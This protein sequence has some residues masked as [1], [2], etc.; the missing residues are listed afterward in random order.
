MKTTTKQPKTIFGWGGG[1]LSFISAMCAVFALT[2]AYAAQTFRWVDGSA[3]WSLPASYQG[4]ETAPGLGDTVEIPNNVT[5][6]VTNAT[7][8][9]V[10]TNLAWIKLLGTKSRVVFDVPENEHYGV[11]CTIRGTSTANADCGV[12]E[13]VKR[14]GGELEFAMSDHTYDGTSLL[15]TKVTVEEGT[16]V[17]PQNYAN[18]QSPINYRRNCNCGIVSVSNG[19]TVVTAGIRDASSS[20]QYGVTVFYELWGEGVV[21]NRCGSPQ[22]LQVNGK[23][24][25]SEFKGQIVPRVRWHQGGYLRLTGTNST[26]TGYF[27]LHSKAICEFQTAGESTSVPSSIGK[28]TFQW[29]DGA[30]YRYI[31]ANETTSKGCNTQSTT[32]M[33][34]TF[35]AGEHGGLTFTSAST[36]NADTQQ[37][38]TF[39]RLVLTGDN[40]NV[41]EIAGSIA[42]WSVDN[43]VKEERV[44]EEVI[45]NGDETTTT[46]LVTNVVTV[47][48]SFPATYV[49]AKRGTGT[50]KF[51]NDAN[52][53]SG[54][55]YI[56]NGTI[57]ATSLGSI[58]GVACSLGT[59]AN[60]TEFKTMYGVTASTSHVDYAVCLGSA[61][62]SGTLEYVG[63]ANAIVANRP[64]AVTG[65]GGEL[66]IS[67]DAQV[68]YCGVIALAG[69]DTTFT[70]SG[71]SANVTNVICDVCDGAG[72]VS[73]V[74]EGDGDWM[75]AGTNTFSGTLSVNG[76]N[77]YVRDPRTKYNW[78]RWVLKERRDNTASDASV[79][80]NE[81]GIWDENGNRM[82]G[83][84]VQSTT[85]SYTRPGTLEEGMCAFDRSGSHHRTV[86][87][88]TYPLDALFDDMIT[89]TD[90]YSSAAQ[91]CMKTNSQ[92]VYVNPEIPHSWIPVVMHLTNS[93]ARAASFD[94][95]QNTS[96]QGRQYKTFEMEGSSDGVHWDS[97][98]NITVTS[99]GQGKWSA[100]NASYTKGTAETHS[101]GYPIA[102]GP[103]NPALA[104]A[105]V[106]SV[107]VAA[108]ARLVSLGGTAPI[109]GLTVDV[110]GA[111]T[112][113]NFEFAE[114]GGTLDVRN[115]P[116]DGA[117]L[118]GA[119]VNC[120]GF[121]NIAGWTLKV[122]GEETRK[123]RISAMNGTLRVLPIG[124]RILF[125]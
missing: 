29:R 97:L 16:L 107:S 21:T 59:A 123:Y 86:N 19:A 28:C 103:V 56:E 64:I 94:L 99:F 61:N 79:R 101:K 35:D 84:L 75:I 114:S 122:G 26:T 32:D 62:T 20:I 63:D 47:A 3:D 27:T 113:E 54:A 53:W 67:S 117:T 88:T 8:Y 50:W 111:G 116:R 55:L 41:C 57:Q 2:G 48:K 72:K 74:K 30:T 70:V 98:T 9:A 95:V 110:S 51:S 39:H 80:I 82:N 71:G 73:L 96:T 65:K 58:M 14:G 40:T 118:P 92:T 76:G 23:T 69:A 7:S 11:G 100:A 77:L 68:T 121:G 22:R 6:Y 112:I 34:A 24:R 5:A 13:V 104:L 38:Q 124:T 66:K 93:T 78:F 18:V 120:T 90:G 83:G 12:G 25:M 44:T 115:L 43:N 85:Y 87:N 89:R 125:R 15:W 91:I 52:P 10:V 102:G 108:G 60:R 37:D 31:G 36:W 45:E 17:L 49:I 106:E 42:T 33:P 4:A 109:K 105:N 46:N 119:Y 81:L 1:E